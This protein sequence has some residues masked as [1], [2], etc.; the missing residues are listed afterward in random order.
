VTRLVDPHCP[1]QAGTRTIRPVGRLLAFLIPALLAGCSGAHGDPRFGDRE[2]G[3]LVITRNACGSCHSIAGIE[4][5]DGRVGP[6]L[7]HFGSQ[8]LFAGTLPNTP[9]ALAR[10]LRSPQSVT[11]GGTMPDMGLTPQQARDAAAYLLTLK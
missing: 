7:T 8:Q 5:A 4:L 3:K 2:A 6:A 9:A 10:F 1:S 11:K